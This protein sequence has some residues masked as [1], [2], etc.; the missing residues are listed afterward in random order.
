MFVPVHVTPTPGT[1]RYRCYR[2]G[3]GPTYPNRQSYDV[4]AFG[5][6]AEANVGALVLVENQPE[7]HPAAAF[8]IYGVR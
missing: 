3:E 5:T 6:D 8:T 2:A 7:W 4:L 1:L